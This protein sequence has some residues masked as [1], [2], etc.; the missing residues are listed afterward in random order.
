MYL[1]NEIASSVRFSGF[2]EGNENMAV[3]I[4]SNDDN[5]KGNDDAPEN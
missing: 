4:K 1:A 5:N 3:Y 2:M